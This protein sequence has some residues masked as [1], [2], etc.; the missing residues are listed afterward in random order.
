[1][2]NGNCP[3]V[4]DAAGV[5]AGQWF[6]VDISMPASCRNLQKKQIEYTAGA[7]LG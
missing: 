2:S 4:C 5:V 6:V 3:D 1:M 7:A